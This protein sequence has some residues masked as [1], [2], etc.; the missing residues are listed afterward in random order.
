MLRFLTEHCKTLV[1]CEVKRFYELGN[2]YWKVYDRY[3]E[4]F[5][6]ISGRSRMQMKYS[7]NYRLKDESMKPF[8]YPNYKRVVRAAVGIDL[9]EEFL[10][11]QRCICKADGAVLRSYPDESYDTFYLLFPSNSLLKPF[12]KS[13]NLMLKSNEIVIKLDGSK[14]YRDFLFTADVGKL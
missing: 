7:Y 5:P 1:E 8:N 10:K 11:Y 3:F 9:A 12:V 2:T 14:S 13:A 6:P 4:T